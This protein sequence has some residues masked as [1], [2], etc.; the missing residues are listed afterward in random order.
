MRRAKA[1]E[2]HDAGASYPE[3]A[4]ELNISVGAAWAL[5]NKVLGSQ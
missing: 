4:K 1:G 2:L 3:I 5:I